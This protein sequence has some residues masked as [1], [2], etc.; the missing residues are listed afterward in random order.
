M[1]ETFESL[2]IIM[3]GAAVLFVVA[4]PV[5][6]FKK[7]KN[8]N[9]TKSGE[10]NK[11]IPEGAIICP[12]CKKIYDDS[13]TTCLND[14]E[15]LI[16]YQGEQDAANDIQKEKSTAPGTDKNATYKQIEELSQLK[17]KGILS[18][19]EFDVKK[20]ELLERI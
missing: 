6:I 17:E 18:Q 4:L 11:E 7:I 10:K 2:I 16:V 8:K 5:I 20:K 12:K 19:E 14:G 3:A 9:K 1:T 15:K 13:W